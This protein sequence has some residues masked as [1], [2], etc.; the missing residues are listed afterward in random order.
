MGKSIRVWAPDWLWEVVDAVP[1]RKAL[2]ADW[3]IDRSIDR[4]ISDIVLNVPA[5]RGV[6]MRAEAA[7]NK[8]IA[9]MK[10]NNTIERRN[11]VRR[12]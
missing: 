10:C 5:I 6:D 3:L 7:I 11:L 12:Q 2:R 1:F 9:V 4:L 8:A